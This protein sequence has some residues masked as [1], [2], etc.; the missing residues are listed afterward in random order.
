[1]TD[2]E[3][4]LRRVTAD[5]DERSIG[6]ALVMSTGAARGRDL[7]GSLEQLRSEK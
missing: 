5:L 2:L 6:W 7:A 3:A 4:A 1:M